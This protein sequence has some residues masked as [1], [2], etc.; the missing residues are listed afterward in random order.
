[1]KIVVLDRKAIGYDTPL[2]PLQELGELVV[3]DATDNYQVAERLYEADVVVLNKVR[4][5][6]E[7]IEQAKGLKLICVFATGYDNID[8]ASARERGVAVCNVPAYSTESVALYTMTTVLALYTH[9]NEYKE[10]VSDGRYSS[11]GSPNLLEPVYHEMQGKVWGIVGLGNIG[12]RVAQ[13]ANAF[14]AKIIATKRTKVD[15]YECVDID[16]LCQRADII[17][18]HCPLNQETRSIINKDR[19]KLMKKDVIIV[20]MARG[21]VLDEDAVAEAVLEGK[22]GAFG[23]DVYSKEPFDLTHP[24]NKILSKKNVIFTPHCAW[25]SYEARERCINIIADNIKAFFSGKIQ[26]RVEK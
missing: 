10:Y 18:V 1:M 4:I 22:V 2:S 23:C 20:N 15:N 12:K 13:F 6:R 16:T 11:S 21:A 19:I 9:L 8:L 17:T 24:Y 7:V 14:G 26:N 3:Y 25:G 5:T